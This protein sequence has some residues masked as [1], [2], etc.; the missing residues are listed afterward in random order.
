GLQLSDRCG[1]LLE[2]ASGCA[3]RWPAGATRA[4]PTI[5]CV[6]AGSAARRDRLE[7]ICRQA[8]IG[9]RRWYQPLLHRHGPAVG[10]LVALPAPH[11]ER[12]ADDLIGLPFFA[13]MRD[14]QLQPVADA[15]RGAFA[16]PL[17][18]TVTDTLETT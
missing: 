8:G 2:A 17:H 5:L 7:D 12:I 10:P 6:R 13:A 3:L 9:T 18:S 1:E 4:A 14:D 11:A 15:V 16:S